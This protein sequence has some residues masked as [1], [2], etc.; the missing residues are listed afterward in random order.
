MSGLVIKVK[1]F[2]RLKRFPEL[3]SE[4]FSDAMT[5]SMEKVLGDAQANSPVDRGFFRSSLSI[6][7]SQA[8]STG[9][10][11][12]GIAGHIFSTS[13]HAPVIEGVD[14]QGNLVDYGRRPGAKF[15]N[16]QALR[17]WV[18]RQGFTKGSRKIIEK[19][20]RKAIPAKTRKVLPEVLKFEATRQEDNEINR[21]AYLIGRAI[22]RRGL[23]R[24][25]WSLFYFRPMHRAIEKNEQFIQ[26]LF[27]Q[28]A[29]KLAR[30]LEGKG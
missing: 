20:L 22:V 2:D 13:Q 10:N 7:V 1:R 5:V 18:R 8:L 23:P 30:K 26:M 21:I 9:N 25:G 24:Q 15:P 28:A 16:V 29:N 27:N 19:K 17:E 4:A 12:L 3:A 6:S 11:P 14:A